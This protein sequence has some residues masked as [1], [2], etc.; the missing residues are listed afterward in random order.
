V[1]TFIHSFGENSILM[2][3]ATDPNP[4]DDPEVAN[5]AFQQV[6]DLF[7][8]PE[9]ERRQEIG[10]LPKPLV[11]QKVQLVFFPDDRKTMVRFNDEVDALA[12]V[13]LKEGIS[14]EKGDPVYSHEIEGLK[15]IELTEDDDPDCAHVI[16]FH[17]GEKWLLHFD[18]RYNKDLSSRYIERASEFIKGAEFYYTQNHMA[19]FADNLYSA[20]ELLAQAILMLFRDRV[21]TESKSHGPLKNRFNH[22]VYLGNLKPEY[23]QAFNSLAT[24]RSKGRYLRGEIRITQEDAATL[25]EYVKGMRDDAIAMLQ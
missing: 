4:L 6:M 7:I 12:K 19:P 13:K 8:L 21:V 22:Y 25:L 24:Q 20:I 10:D 9:V 5:R 1:K 11:I 14:K 15:E 17:I 3:E 23:A 16:I 18:F 2:T